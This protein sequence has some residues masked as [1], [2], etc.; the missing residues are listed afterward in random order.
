VLADRGVVC[1]S[2]VCGRESRELKLMLLS[3]EN[4]LRLV[5]ASIGRTETIDHLF[6]FCSPLQD[7]PPSSHT[8]LQPP[9]SWIT[10]VIHS[11]FRILFISN[12]NSGNNFCPSTHWNESRVSKNPLP[13][14][15]RG[16]ALHSYSL[17]TRSLYP[18]LLAVLTLS[19]SLYFIIFLGNSFKLS[20]NPSL[21]NFL[22]FWRA[23]HIY[24]IGR[25]KITIPSPDRIPCCNRAME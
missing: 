3:S 22:V 21:R 6:C 16:P 19:S 18:V 4:S 2:F 15:N 17:Y 20:Q 8:P 10:R 23:G 14:L 1:Q 24:G 9:P 25:R 5:G 12:S 11:Y 7:L 13:R